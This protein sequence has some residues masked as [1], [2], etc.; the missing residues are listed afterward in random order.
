M[1]TKFSDF[2]LQ[3]SAN[4]TDQIVGLNGAINSRWTLATIKALI[5]AN[6]VI[7][8]GKT[9]TVNNTLTLAGTDGSSV[10]VGAGGTV[11]PI[12]YSGSATDLTAGTVPVA[13]LPIFGSATAGAVPASGGGTVN[14]L[15]ADGTWAAAP[16]K[17]SSQVASGSPATITFSSIPNT[18]THLRITGMARDTKATTPASYAAFIKVNGDA[19]A[20]NYNAVYSLASAAT[21]SSVT[22]AG[23]TN[24]AAVVN[25][26]G[27]F[28]TANAFGVFDI[29]IPYYNN[30]TFFKGMWGHSFAFTN[31]STPF[32]EYA[33]RGA[34][35]MSTA[36]ITSLA[37]TAG[38]TAFLNG[39]TFDLYGIP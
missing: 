4:L 3:G 34:Q 19:T 16:Q 11:Q 25:V 15:R 23:T 12:A 6:A 24:G 26:P 37:L 36:A 2:V 17:I 29:F 28:T 14:V 31:A 10:N 27:T 7:A 8:A 5:L 33:D 20:A 32:Q 30:T 21:M 18:F 38:G 1:A 22:V 13:R 9:L 39:S 35:W